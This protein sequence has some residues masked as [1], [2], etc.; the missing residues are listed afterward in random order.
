MGWMTGLEPETGI[1]QGRVAK[2]QDLST[3]GRSETQDVERHA[4]IVMPIVEDGTSSGQQEVELG[5]PKS[6][7]GTQQEHNGSAGKMAQSD[8][9]RVIMAWS[10]L[11]HAIKQGILAMIDA[12]RQ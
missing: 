6:I 12:A 10:S 5:H 9:E 7:A 4:D 1:K 3:S 2:G 8:L 11:P